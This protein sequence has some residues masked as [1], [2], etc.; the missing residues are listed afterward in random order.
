M[1]CASLENCLSEYRPREILIATRILGGAGLRS[2]VSREY[3]V[4]VVTQGPVLGKLK[5]L[6]AID[7]F[8]VEV[9]YVPKLFSS[10]YIFKRE[11]TVCAAF[12]GDLTYDVVSGS[13]TG[14]LLSNCGDDA[15]GALKFFE[16]LW[17]RARNILEV[18][19]YLVGRT[20]DW[21]HY[22]VIAELRSL[23]LKGD[24]E[25]EIVD[26]LVREHAR[27]VFGIDD[28]DEIA[29]RYWSTI[30]SARNISVKLVDDPTTGLPITAP[31][32]YYSVRILRNPTD[33][34]NG[35]PCLKTTVK[36]IERSL[37]Y[38]PAS[39]VHEAWKRSLKN[40]QERRKI[41]TSPYLPALLLLTGK[42]EI[43]Y[44]RGL[45]TRTYRLK[46]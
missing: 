28:Y 26:R 25:E 36:L 8:N 46:K 39:P 6:E 15:L 41:D 23:K 38:A 4:K 3:S 42:V 40:G 34:C 1:L 32:V 44:D 30:F 43:D 21:N 29:R 12:G 16:K 31:L 35:S 45:G 2:L 19:P 7:N 37:K 22:R 18:D 24:D 14:V 11:Q 17:E 5:M 20:R 10:F 27:R 9:R 33:T 13:S